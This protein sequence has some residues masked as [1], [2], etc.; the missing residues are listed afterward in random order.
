V[1][2]AGY[3]FAS[4]LKLVAYI[5]E[6]FVIG[7]TRT[8]NL[9]FRDFGVVMNLSHYQGK[10]I[11]LV[12]DVQGREVVL[13]GTTSLRRAANEQQFLKVTVA[14]EDDAAIGAPVFFISEPRWKDQIVDGQTYGCD[15][16]L[17]LSESAVALES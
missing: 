2:G 7:I 15:L 14:D 13:R 16:L 9:D 6:R 17:N 3:S 12:M 1:L 11:A 5:F 4:H 8:T 10:R